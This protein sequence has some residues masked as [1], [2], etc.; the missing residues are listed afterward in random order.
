MKRFLLTILILS[1]LGASLILPVHAWENTTAKSLL[2]AASLTPLATGFTDLDRVVSNIFAEKFTSNTT[3]Y[4]KVKICYD[5]VNT[6][7]SY[8]GV[9]PNSSIYS[10]IKLYFFAIL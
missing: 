8:Q 10:K 6:G 7:A 9:E 4:E 5:Y 3:T 2:N 1:L